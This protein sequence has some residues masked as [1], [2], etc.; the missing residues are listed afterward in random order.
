M[1]YFCTCRRPCTH[2]HTHIHSK[3]FLLHLF[4]SWHQQ[5][6]K[7]QDSLHFCLHIELVCWINAV[8]K[9]NI[10][11]PLLEWHHHS[12]PVAFFVCFEMKANPNK[13][14]G[15]AFVVCQVVQL[16]NNANNNKQNWGSAQCHANETKAK[17]MKRTQHTFY[18]F[19][20]APCPCTVRQCG[21]TTTT[22]TMTTTTTNMMMTQQNREKNYTDTRHGWQTFLKTHHF[23]NSS[24]TSHS[25]LAHFT[26]PWFLTDYHHYS[27]NYYCHYIFH[28]HKQLNAHS[29]H[30]HTCTKRKVF[31]L[32][33]KWT[34]QTCL[35]TIASH[36]RSNSTLLVPLFLNTFR[37][38]VV[39]LFATSFLI[40]CI[41]RVKPK[42]HNDK[43]KTSSKTMHRFQEI[44]SRR[45]RR[46]FF[47]Q[48]KG[49]TW[50]IN[51]ERVDVS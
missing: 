21:A 38:R 2:T 15:I 3:D 23:P 1:N 24:N 35:P 16:N 36:L 45:K 34:T 39:C 14:V 37:L 9:C 48:S 49:S 19:D 47:L 10:R 46:L 11:H 25:V 40:Y 6:A 41:F 50:V 18:L 33:A 28:W 44:S 29:A 5:N 4:S 42:T 43:Q 13:F 12:A 27:N 7:M 32:N 20:D 31:V 51:V 8:V 30:M 26:V 17:V 22:T